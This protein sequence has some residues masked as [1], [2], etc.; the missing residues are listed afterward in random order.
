MDAKLIEKL[1]EL[2]ILPT[3]KTI[4]KHTPKT[5]TMKPEIRRLVKEK[6]K[7]ECEVCGKD[8]KRAGLF[9]FRDKQ[10][11]TDHIP[12]LL[13]TCRICIYK[14]AFGK[15]GIMA[16]KRSNQ[17]EVETSRYIGLD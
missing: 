11:V 15:R 2:D 13:R 16:R 6:A 10:M 12:K 9:E 8:V 17:V 5:Y 7:F 1:V 14:L 4:A 3:P